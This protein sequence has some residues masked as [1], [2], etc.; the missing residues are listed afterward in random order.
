MRITSSGDAMMKKGTSRAGWNELRRNRL[1]FALVLAYGVIWL[2]TAI[3]PVHREDWLLEN[4]LVFAAVPVLV[5]SYRH[6]ILSNISY[7]LLF[8]FLTLHAI[9][10]HFTYTDMP[11]GNW[12]RD[13]LNLSRNYYDRVVHFT[14]G[15]LVAYP[16]REVLMV[17]GGL[18]GRWSYV[19]PVH[20]VASRLKDRRKT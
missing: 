2:V 19:V 5:V 12:M 4:L 13:S 1:L 16:F 14:F 11:L 6:G 3:R 7:V 8:V 20:V 9:G 15:L 17:V 10:A 18:R